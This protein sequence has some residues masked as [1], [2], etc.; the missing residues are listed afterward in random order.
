MQDL[1][2][3]TD[4]LRNILTAALNTSPVFGGNPPTFSV[5]VS[6]QHPQT[7]SGGSDCELSLYLFHVGADKFLANSFWS[8]AAQSGGG[9][10]SQPVAFE[11]LS[12]DLWYMLSAQSQASYVQE[13]QVLGVAMQALHEHATFKIPTPTPLPNSVTPSE[14]TL[15]LESPTFDEMSRLWQA[16]SLPLRTTAQYRVSV[17]FLTPDKLPD[18]QPPV[19]VANLAAAPIDAIVDPSLP[20]LLATRRTVNY[21]APGPSTRIVQQSPASTAPAPNGVAGQVVSLDALMLADTDH[22]LLVSFDAAGVATETDVT[23]T[24][25][26]ALS[27]PYPSP[28]AHGVPFLLRPPAGA[29]APAPGRYELVAR[30]PSLPGWRSNRVPLNIAPWISPTGGPLLAHNGAGIYTMDVRNVPNTGVTLRMGTVELAR[31]PSG[32]TPNPGEWQCSGGSLITFAAPD[33]TPAGR[34]QI[35]VRANDVEADPA[36]WA[37]V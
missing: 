36:L 33:G 29:G 22:V 30:R 20:H 4:T 34:H 19:Q 31:V 32:N 37:V 2:I 35:W 6:G 24:W 27:T 9:T 23:A 17:I 3:V 21:T 16:L 14:A 10:G 5:N 11:P 7:P 15:V 12:L 28:P 1:S 25:K 18:P 13:Q 8:Q 26:V